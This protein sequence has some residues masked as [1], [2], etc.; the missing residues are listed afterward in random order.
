V[1]TEAETIPEL[2]ALRHEEDGDAKAVVTAAASLT[3]GELDDASAGLAARLAADGVVKGDRVGLVAPNGIE[4]AVHAMA[5]AR[6]GAVL[7]P[8]STLLRPP[9]LLAQLTTASVT[10]LIVVPEF[11]GRRSVGDLEAAAPGLPAT[12]RSG[13]RHPAAPSLRRLW[14]LG[15]LPAG[16]V[17]PELLGALEARVRPA[18]DLVVLFTSGSRGAPKG[19]IHTHGAALRATAANLDA[20]CIRPGERLYI[21]MPFFWMGGFGGGLLS[22]LAAGATLLTEAEPEPAR[23]LALL[24]RERVTLFRGWPD[25]AARLAAHPSFAATNLSS[26]GDASLPAVLPAERRPAPGARANLFGMTETFGPYCGERLD[27]DLAPDKQG[28]C[29]RP[30]AGIEV[31]I[32]D[33]ESELELPAGE[34]GE[35]RLR[36]PN[37][38]RGICGRARSSVFTTDGSYRTGDL[39]RLDADGYLFYA[40]RLDDMVKIKGATVYPSEVESAIRSVHGVRQAYVTDVPGAGGQREMA[41]LVIS[42]EPLDTLCAAVR[43]RLSS[44]KVPTRWLV[45]AEQT[46]VPMLASAKVDKTALQHLLADRGYDGASPD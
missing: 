6:I 37:L 24:E 19:V 45:T 4:W 14:M 18:D 40:G 12:I 30:F 39:G 13:D 41:A 26:L 43:T 10:H 16:A 25:Q 15:D 1:G 46:V 31:R 33:P 36:G 8:L 20:R 44:F 28:S 7:V 38:L 9:E 42:N 27:T 34:Q 2:L 23:T 29:G 32:V 11:R 21:P 17:S 35:I 5:V 3:Y 22:A